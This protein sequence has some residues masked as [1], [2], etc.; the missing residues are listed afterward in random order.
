MPR[1]VPSSAWVPGR[2]QCSPGLSP[3]RRALHS[4]AHVLPS[5]GPWLL[6]TARLSL[7][8]VLPHH[9]PL[10]PLPSSVPCAGCHTPAPAEQTSAPALPRTG[11]LQPPAPY[12]DN[13]LHE[14]A[15]SLPSRHT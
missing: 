13:T 7:S 12:V 3:A 2:S 1:C 8:S 11:E 9:L 4:E 15:W 14:H 6:L 10:A 5:S